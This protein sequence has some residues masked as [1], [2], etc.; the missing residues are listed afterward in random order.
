MV[1]AST[2]YSG[3]TATAKATETNMWEAGPP[4]VGMAWWLWVI[5]AV[6]IVALA[7]WAKRRRGRGPEHTRE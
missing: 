6:A 2:T 4:A 7:V 5:I 3:I 1:E